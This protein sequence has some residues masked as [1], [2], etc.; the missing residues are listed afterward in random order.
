MNDKTIVTVADLI[1]ALSDH[2]PAAPVRIATSSALHM[3]HTI[4]RVVRAPGDSD[5]A[6]VLPNDAPVVRISTGDAECCLP[7][8]AADALWS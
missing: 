5:S 3:D 2:D 6:C 1:A 8:S 7:D 4:G